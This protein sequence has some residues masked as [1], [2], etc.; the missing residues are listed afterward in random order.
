MAREQTGYFAVHKQQCLGALKELMRRPLGNILTLAVLS[1]ALTLPAS[2]YLLAK[3]VA[4]VAQAWQNP[5]QLTL[6]LDQN[7]SQPVANQFSDQLRGWPEIESVEY[8]SPQQ[9]LADFRDHAGF[10]QALS[11]LDENPLPSVVVVRP[12][13]EWQ[14]SERATEL[15]AKIRT[16]PTVDEVRLDSDWLQRLAAI[17]DLAVT[18]ATLMSGL[19]LFAV[20]LIVG[21]T[22]RL[23]VQNHKNEIQVMKLVGATDSFILRPYLY[24]GAWYGFIGAAVAWVLTAIV[25]I[26]LDNAVAKLAA[27]YDSSYRLVGLRWDET[28]ILFMVA[29]FLGLLAARLS[30]G[31]HL[32]EI[33]PI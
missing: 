21:N 24:T 9:G 31:R 23:Q 19:M 22:L 16:E 8:I 12:A 3:N 20:F 26:L 29:A 1:F 13:S 2:F 15:A 7:I 11:L 10:D 30:A 25:T 6:Y 32:K 14:T 17:K 28:L 4:L 27:L 5:T 18:M 33:E